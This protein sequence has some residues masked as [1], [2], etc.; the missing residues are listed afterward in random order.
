MISEKQLLLNEIAE[1]NKQLYSAYA[2]IRDLQEEIKSYGVASR[3]T[4]YTGE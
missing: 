2:R 1:L 3:E 4:E